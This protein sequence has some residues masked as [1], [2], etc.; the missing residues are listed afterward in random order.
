[1]TSNT[2]DEALK[3][4]CWKSDAAIAADS[5]ALNKADLQAAISSTVSQMK[6]RNRGR[7]RD[8]FPFLQKVTT[9]LDPK[10]RIL[11]KIRAIEQY[12]VFFFCVNNY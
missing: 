11:N 7:K 6:V 4:G 3:F 1:M 10:M 12:F 9:R 8:L 2:V 5:A